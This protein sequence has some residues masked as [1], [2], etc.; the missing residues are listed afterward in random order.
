MGLGKSI[1]VRGFAKW[2]K[3]DPKQ[4]ILSLVSLGYGV[5]GAFLGLLVVGP[6]VNIEFTMLIFGLLLSTGSLFVVV[7][8]LQISDR[9]VAATSTIGLVW[10]FMGIFGLLLGIASIITTS[11]IMGMIGFVTAFL[12]MRLRPSIGTKQEVSN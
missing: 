5:L 11:I 7:F 12:M 4:G 8:N 1:V 2:I 6:A 9:R 3:T 10:I